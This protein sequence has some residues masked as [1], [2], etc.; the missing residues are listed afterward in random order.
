[1]SRWLV[2]FLTLSLWSGAILLAARMV[3]PGSLF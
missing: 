1:M 2:P 3:P